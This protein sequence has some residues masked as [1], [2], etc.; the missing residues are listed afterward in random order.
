MAKKQTLTPD[1]TINPKQ[2]LSNNILLRLIKIIDI[3]FIAVIYT[4]L[5]LLFAKITDKILGKFDTTKEEKKPKWQI[6]VEMFILIWVFGV[7]MYIS[8]NIVP[9]VPF[10]LDGYQGF[11]HAKVKELNVPIIFSFIYMLFG[12]HIKSKIIYFYNNIITII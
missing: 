3:G 2:T 5:A 6:T 7:L 9:L 8:R 10:P 12:E 4:G 11:S 1:Q